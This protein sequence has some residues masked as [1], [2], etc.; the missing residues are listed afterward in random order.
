VL[1]GGSLAA[2]ALA[3]AASALVTT[4]AGQLALRLLM[5]AAAAPFTPQAAGVAGL[6][7]PA[8]RRSSAI[9]YVF[10][11]WSLAGA[12]GM[13]M[14]ALVAGRY[15]WQWSYAA[16]ALLAALSFVLLVWRLPGGLQT[17]PVKLETWGELMQNPLV[18]LLLLLTMLLTSGQF[19]V[20]TFIAPLLT[21]VAHAS[22]ESVSLVFAVYGVTGFV[23]N[24]LV[25][26]LVHALGPYKTEQLS[27]G[28]LIVGSATFALTAG[29]L[30]GMVL[31]V[32]V[33]GL[34][35]AS[36]NSMQQARLVGAAPLLAGASVALNTSSLYVGQA[37]GSA[38]GG[39]LFARQQDLTIG[40][41]SLLFIVVGAAVLWL[42][43][44][45]LQL[46]PPAGEAT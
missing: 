43:R 10:L 46:R 33:W 29:S 24:V 11:G 39:A 45:R 37:I 34:G 40:Y 30:S 26:R 6:L 17:A 42:T 16:M 8:E 18:L 1:L 2:I 32:A 19:A 9:P 7:V 35:F 13:P 4:F 5:L 3:H 44:P 25:T 27:V 38:L 12:F 15:G 23:G 22:S 20:F 41:V 28:A 21:R 31:G 36:T 14:V